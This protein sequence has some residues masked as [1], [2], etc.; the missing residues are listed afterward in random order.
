MVSLN[1]SGS[2]ANYAWDNNAYY[3]A[4][5]VLWNGSTGT[6]ASWPSW[7]GFDA[8]STY[9]PGAPTGIWTFVRPNKYEAGRAHIVVYNWDLASSVSVDVSAALT[10]GKHYEVR[11]AQNYFGAPVAS[12]VYDGG[13]IRI[14]MTGLTIPPANGNVPVEPVHSA[15]Q[16]G[17]FV[18]VPLE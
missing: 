15:P 10:R 4:G 14:P 17:A 11:D 18:L 16:F 3:G 9:H 5:S 12:G 6:Y 1:T 2:T 8:H 13:L 7:T